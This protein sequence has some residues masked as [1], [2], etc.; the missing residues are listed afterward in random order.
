ML[1]LKSKAQ[2][3]KVSIGLLKASNT[4]AG[5]QLTHL[6]CASC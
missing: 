1:A 6:D 5:E 2:N 3:N 4:A